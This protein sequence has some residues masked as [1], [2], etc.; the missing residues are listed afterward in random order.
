VADD[1]SS[2]Q[3]LTVT[4]ELTRV[5][6]S[7]CQKI[8]RNKAAPRK[9][10]TFV[11]FRKL[12]ENLGVEIKQIIYES[13]KKNIVPTT[14]SLLQTMK[15]KGFDVECSIDTFRLFLRSIGFSYKV[16]NQ[17]AAIMESPRLKRAR[18]EYIQ[19]IRKYREEKRPIIFLDETWYDTH[20]VVKKGITD[21]SSNCVLNIP[22]SR[23]KRIIVLHAE[24]KNGWIP[25]ALLLSAKNIANCSA[26]YDQDMDGALFETW[27]KHQLLPNV[28][29]NSVIVMDNARYHSRHLSKKPNQNTKKEDILNCIRANQIEVPAGKTTKKELIKII[30]QSANISVKYVCDTM[31]E[32]NGHRVLRLPPYYCVLNPIE[33]MWST[34]KTAIRRHNT[35][36]NLSAGVVDLIRN[37][38]QNVKCNAWKNC[39]QHVIEV[40]NHYVLP[41]TKDLLRQILTVSLI[42]K[43]RKMTCN[44]FVHFINKYNFVGTYL[45]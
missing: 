25:G 6:Y 3:S 38:V 43:V 23:G 39:V 18:F 34:L 35:S 8:I 28:P 31:A 1:G 17:R 11:K 27:F 29:C 30:N 13:Y 4:S 15:E 41:N 26:D 44:S 16:I 10:D 5:P 33:M 12:N 42:R 20:D 37:E 40:E 7:T 19:Q 2:Y 45:F 24:N 32:R 36:P 22:P 21:G 9:K 14:E